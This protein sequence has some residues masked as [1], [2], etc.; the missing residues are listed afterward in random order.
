M[1]LLVRGL[2]GTG[3]S[4]LG[5][6]LELAGFVHVEADAFFVDRDGIY[7]FDAS[8]LAAAHEWCQ[9]E[10]ERALDRKRHVVVTNTFSTE[11]EVAPYRDI[12]RRRGEVLRIVTMEK[13]Y[14][15]IHNVPE[16]TIQRMRDR[17]EAL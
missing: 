14:G 5:G 8:R 9:R 11:W 3:K 16:A 1:L 7:R 2:P 17:W 4:T 6:S 13:A 15:N 12:A 10:T